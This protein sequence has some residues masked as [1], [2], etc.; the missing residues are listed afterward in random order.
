MKVGDYLRGCIFWVT[1]RVILLS[2][3]YFV[4]CYVVFFLVIFYVMMV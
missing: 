1:V 4:T 3:A 2:V